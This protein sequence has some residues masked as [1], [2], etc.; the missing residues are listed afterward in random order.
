[1]SDA[2]ARD[3]I[4][5][6]VV[7]VLNGHTSNLVTNGRV[8]VVLM[9]TAG[10]AILAELADAGY[11]VVRKSQIERLIDSLEFELEGMI[12]SRVDDV[13]GWMKAV[14]AGGNAEQWMPDTPKWRVADDVA[15]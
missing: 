7:A 8:R 15:T 9:P 13:V 1:M 3:V 6:A 10:D 5:K 12:S 11:A 14:V 4:E 2:D